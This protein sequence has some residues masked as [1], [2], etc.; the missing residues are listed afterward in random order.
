METKI[1][2]EFKHNGIRYIARVFNNNYGE[3][4][5]KENMTRPKNMKDIIRQY[6]KKY[7]VEIST[8]A[9]KMTTH[10]AVRML[11]KYL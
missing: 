5:Y 4:I 9:N 3:I 10:G 7:N 11:L 6:L 1:E 8:E 2:K